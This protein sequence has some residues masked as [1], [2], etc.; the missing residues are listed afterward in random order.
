MAQEKW[1]IDGE[2]TI[3]IET[4]RNLKVALIGGQ[5]DMIGHDEPG[6]RIEVH[7]VDGKPLKVTLDGDTLEID[8]PQL[9]WDNF[10]DVFMS[11][12]GTARADVSIM[13]PRDVALKFGVDLREGAHQ[14]AD[15]RQDQHGVR[16]HGRRRRHRRPGAQRGQRR[17]RRAR[18]PRQHR[19]PHRERRCHGQRGDRRFHSDAVSGEVFLDVAGT[20]DEVRVKS[21]S[22]NI[23]VRLAA[24]VAAQYKREHHRGPAAAGRLRD[25][26]HP[27]PVHR[28]VRRAGRALARLQRQ[29]GV[30]QRR[31]CC[32]GRR[33]RHESP[34]FRPRS[35]APVPA[36]P[37]RH[38]ADARLRAHP[39][40][41]DPFGG[42]YIPSAGTIYPRL[43]K[44]E[45]EGLVT[46]TT[47]GRKT[48]Y[49]ITDAGR[50]ELDARQS[51]LDGIE[52]DVTDSVR[53]L[54]DEVRSSVDSAMR[55]LRADLAASAR[56][57][58]RETHQAGRSETPRTPTRRAR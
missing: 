38:R 49:A 27:R 55:S 6:A 9:G 48:V 32:T 13:V 50:A 19:L 30:R 47:D 39:G 24:G 3:D 16:R 56:E 23:T 2:K 41:G 8:H 18:A 31:R 40:A 58:R 54:A 26:R 15:R 14:R 1:M 21:V 35:P 42:T 17:D 46:K 33:C 10:I 45:D 20:P 5:V 37:A 12:R 36:E 7:S 52:S 51:E 44:L 11:F 29:H 4:V 57:A 25:P 28:Q 53:R 22:G 43:A 34:G